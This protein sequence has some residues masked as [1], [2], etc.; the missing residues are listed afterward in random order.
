VLSIE[1]THCHLPSDTSL[2]PSQC[3]LVLDLR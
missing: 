2:N 1:I 3:R